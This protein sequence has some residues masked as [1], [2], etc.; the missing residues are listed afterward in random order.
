[1]HCIQFSVVLLKPRLTLLLLTLT[2]PLLSTNHLENFSCLTSRQSTARHRPV[3]NNVEKY[4]RLGYTVKTE[5]EISPP[6]V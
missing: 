3:Y 6:A 1:M 5:V 4:G 2:V